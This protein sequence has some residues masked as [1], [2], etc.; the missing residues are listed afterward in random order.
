MGRNF[1]RDSLVAADYKRM[2]VT[3]RGQAYLEVN[4]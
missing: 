1:R 3:I 4:Y 2:E